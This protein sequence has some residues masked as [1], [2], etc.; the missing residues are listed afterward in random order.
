MK[1]YYCFFVCE[2]QLDFLFSVAKNLWHNPLAKGI[3]KQL[4]KD[5]DFWNC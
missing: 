2:W 3:Q 1:M 5:F 4:K